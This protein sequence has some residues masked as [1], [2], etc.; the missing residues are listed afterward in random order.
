MFYSP[1]FLFLLPALLYKSD[2]LYLFVFLFIFQVVPTKFQKLITADITFTDNCVIIAIKR[3]WCNGNLLVGGEAGEFFSSSFLKIS[4]TW[5][6]PRTRSKKCNFSNC[7]I[8]FKFIVPS[9]FFFDVEEKRMKIFLRL[10]FKNQKKKY[11]EI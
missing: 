3:H 1:S 2:S 4:F 11:F 7:L 9:G 10:L 8:S 5:N 6:N